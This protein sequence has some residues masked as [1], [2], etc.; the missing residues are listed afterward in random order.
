MSQQRGELNELAVALR[1]RMVDDALRRRADVRDIMDNPHGAAAGDKGDK[2]VKLRTLAE[3]SECSDSADSAKDAVVE[4]FWKAQSGSSSSA[5]TAPIRKQEIM[6]KENMRGNETC[7][8][9]KRRTTPG[10]GMPVQPQAAAPR[11]RRQRL[12]S[13]TAKQS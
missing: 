11:P 4:T 3:A 10:L 5:K 12:D 13:V 6:L 9:E 2:H 7:H 8:K 1:R